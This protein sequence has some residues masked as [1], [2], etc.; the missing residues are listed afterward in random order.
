[1]FRI[2]CDILQIYNFRVAK[3]ARSNCKDSR[4]LQK[5]VD[6]Q[7]FGNWCDINNHNYTHK[8]H[9]NLNFNG[10]ANVNIIIPDMH[11]S[12]DM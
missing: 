12:E 3:S 7:M 10:V 6:E 11:A 8:L 4:M 1:M 2:V 9:C 5:L